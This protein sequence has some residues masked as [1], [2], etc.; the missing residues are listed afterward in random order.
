M[1]RTLGGPSR[2][3]APRLRW[4]GLEPPPVAAGIVVPRRDVVGGRSVSSGIA[5]S[6]RRRSRRSLA[7][8]PR[9]RRHRAR[10]RRRTAPVHGEARTRRAR[11][12]RRPRAGPG[13][14]GERR[15]RGS[16]SRLSR[17]RRRARRR[18]PHRRRDPVLASV[19]V[20]AEVDVRELEHRQALGTGI[21]DNVSSLAGP[22]LR[23]SRC[24]PP[25]PRRT[26]TSTDVPS[27]A[28]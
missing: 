16:R 9:S 11:T 5:T 28:I 19:R 18:A 23:H 14:R 22:A 6:G 26:P 3:G 8:P 15:E 24:R 1:R 13:P 10:S 12:G 20:E 7:G 4:A 25:G 27:T 17:A 2:S 21:G